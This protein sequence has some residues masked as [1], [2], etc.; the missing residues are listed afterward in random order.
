MSERGRIPS[1][2][3]DSPGSSQI[4]SRRLIASKIGTPATLRRV[5]VRFHLDSSTSCP[6]RDIAV[7]YT[8][9]VASILRSRDSFDNE[10][11]WSPT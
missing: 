1:K 10:M 5:A 4:D 9:E 8:G 6:R 11:N 7:V 2:G 3:L